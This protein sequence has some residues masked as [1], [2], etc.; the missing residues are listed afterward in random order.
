ML[1]SLCSMSKG[2]SPRLGEL[3]VHTRQ[4]LCTWRRSFRPG[5]AALRAA[6]Y[7]PFHLLH[8]TSNESV[9]VA[10][11][12]MRSQAVEEGSQERPKKRTRCLRSCLACRRAKQ[13]CQLPDDQVEPTEEPLPTS[14]ACR[15]CQA[16]DQACFVVDSVPLVGSHRSRRSTTQPSETS[17]VGALGRR[18]AAGEQVSHSPTFSPFSTAANAAHPTTSRVISEDGFDE[19]GVKPFNEL[20][21]FPPEKAAA[22]D[23]EDEEAESA[24]PSSSLSQLGKGTSEAIKT[25][26]WF[27]VVYTVCRPFELLGYLLMRHFGPH[28]QLSQ[29][30]LVND[31]LMDVVRGA[32]DLRNRFQIE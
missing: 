3:P 11:F 19:A 22:E 12:A 18:A 10:S 32:A 1:S 7:L 26:S 6:A 28:D 2:E 20:R 30:H 8:H 9:A 29:T 15:R 14:L 27:K 24:P 17:V 5:G 4:H 23:G 16:L 31:K 13:R 25:R 21:F